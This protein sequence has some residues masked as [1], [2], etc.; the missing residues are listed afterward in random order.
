MCVRLWKP[1]T[2]IIPICLPSKISDL[3]WEL[4]PLVWSFC[5]PNLIMP[6][7][8][9]DFPSQL[10][11][12]TRTLVHLYVSE[13]GWIFHIHPYQPDHGRPDKG[14]GRDESHSNLAW[15]QG[16][17]GLVWSGR[18]KRKLTNWP[19]LAKQQET[20]APRWWHQRCPHLY[21]DLSLPQQL[22]K[23][24]LLAVGACSRLTEHRTRRCVDLIDAWCPGTVHI[25]L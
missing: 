11:N 3:L 19:W 9:N 10:T 7:S 6:Q 18:R 23:P 22:M 4:L 16:C 12:T 1:L 14:E 13:S 24:L 20:R 17:S 15:I 8:V 2:Y 25:D 5:V 21:R